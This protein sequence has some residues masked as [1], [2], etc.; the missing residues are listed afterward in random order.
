MRDEVVEVIANPGSAG[1]RGARA[2]D[3]LRKRLDDEGMPHTIHRTDG[4]GDAHRWARERPERDR[5]GPI[6]VLGGDGTL[7]EVANG[8]MALET[9]E[10]RPPIALLPVGTGNDFHRMLRS[11]GGID[12]LVQ[13]LRSGVERPFDVGRVRFDGGERVFVNLL[14]IGLDVAVLE[15]RARFRLLPGLLQ[16]LAALM[17][18]LVRFRPIPMAVEYDDESGSRHRLEGRTL[19]TAVTVGP[20]V[21]GGFKLSPDARPDDGLLD[22]FQV[23]RLS[24]GEIMVHLPRVLRGTQREGPRIHLRT[25]RTAEI[26]RLDGSRFS[27]ELDGELMAEDTSRLEIE[28]LPGALTFLD[29]PEPIP[30]MGNGR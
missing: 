21:G 9:S 7:H 29:V 5:S 28:L 19:L 11:E 27:F 18:A 30:S 4:P 24:P 25:L 16:Y 3:R 26:S 22:L 15:R 20:S 13:V 12:P 2:I 1:G 10:P 17:V 14:G 8:L 6:L 23:E